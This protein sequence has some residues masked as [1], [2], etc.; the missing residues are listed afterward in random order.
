MTKTT[1]A[2]VLIGVGVVMVLFGIADALGA[3]DDA[4]NS[5]AVTT[6]APAATEATLALATTTTL[7][8]TSTSPVGSSTTQTS[9]TTE[10][11]TTTSITTAPTETVE[12]FV[13][14][15]AAAIASGDVDFLVNR[16]HPAVVG[17]FGPALCRTWIETEI[18]ELLD[19]QV[20]GPTVG[21]HAQTFT[22]PAGTGTIEEAFS[23]P[24]NF[25]FQG[26]KFD[27]EGDFALVDGEM[28]WMGQCR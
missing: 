21:P 12:E 18:L 14:A 24:V 25:V 1:L 16:L 26:Q 8:A 17:G 27:A 13:I 9:T 3:D 10:P 7:P 15:F 5:A 19:Y 4:A 20:T 23:A 2:Y 28:R 22:T 6:S 11:P